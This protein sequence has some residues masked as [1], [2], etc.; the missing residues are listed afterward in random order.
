VEAVRNKGPYGHFYAEL[1]RQ[2]PG[3]TGLNGLASLYFSAGEFPFSGQR[4]GS[5]APGDE[6]PTVVNQKCSG[7]FD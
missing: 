7:D 5:S 6:N 3:E 4:P 2:F 1:L